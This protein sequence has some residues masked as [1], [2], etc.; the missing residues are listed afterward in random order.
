MSIHIFDAF[1]QFGF[2]RRS[3]VACVVLS[4]SL[5]PLGIFLLL[6]RMSLVGDALSHAVLPGVAIGY[7]FAGM[8]L[9]Y[10]G[11]GGFVAG[12]FVALTS[13]WISKRTKLSEDSTFAGLYL[14]SLALGVILVSYRK[15]SIDLLH[16]LF[17]SLLAVDNA[18]L[19]FIGVVVSITILILAICYRAI[20][21]ESFNSSFF[22]VYSSRYSIYIHALFMG[23]VVLNLIAGFQVLGTL[24]S[25]GLMMLPAISARCWTDRLPY[26]LMI[27][28]V[29]GMISSLFGLSWS[30]YQS[31]PAGPAI[32][33]VALFIFILSIF[34]G[35]KKGMLRQ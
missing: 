14:G 32:I 2:M 29:F 6:R 23:L 16:L 20:V 35:S 10:M 21:Y 8:S 13:S 18:A 11:V 30:W 5:P 7:L 9:F 22:S 26:M 17:G 1:C 24:M 4:F 3:L 28:I 12:L 25:V 15:N 33:L 31:I 19:V 27:S 34:C